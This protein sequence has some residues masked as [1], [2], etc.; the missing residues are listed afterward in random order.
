[1]VCHT[2][3]DVT[4]VT[5]IRTNASVDGINDAVIV[6]VGIHRDCIKRSQIAGAWICKRDRSRGGRAVNLAGHSKWISGLMLLKIY[7]ANLY[8]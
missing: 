6:T 8:K 3:G 4:S 5:L 1:M 2:L 7:S